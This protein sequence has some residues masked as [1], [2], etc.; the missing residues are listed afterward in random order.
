MRVIAEGLVTEDSPPRLIGGRER[1]SGRVVF[2]CPSGALYEP[3][4]LSRSGTLWSYT[5]QR[6]RP[7]SPPYA[8]PEAFRPWPVG[9]IELP[10]EVIVEARLTDVAFED[11]HIGMPLELTLIPLDPDAADPVMIPAFRPAGAAA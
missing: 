7:K 9:Y 1:T 5:I 10:G 3:V 2:P 11:I 4:A 8:G 6:Y